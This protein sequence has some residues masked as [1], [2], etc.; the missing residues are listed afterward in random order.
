MSNALRRPAALLL[1]LSLAAVIPTVATAQDDTLDRAIEAIGG[2][3]ALSSLAG[4]VVESSGTRNALD[5]GPV[6]G[7]PAALGS[8]FESTATI[9]LAS[10]SMRIDYSIGATEFGAPREVSEIV[11][12]DVGY[13]DGQNSLVAPPGASPLLSDRVA[14]IRVQQQLLNPHLL[15]L[16][17]LADPS[18][19]SASSAGDGIEI[20]HGSTPITL[21]VDADGVLTSASTMESDPLRRDVELVVDYGDWGETTSGVSFPG[22]VSISYDGN[23]VH[24]ESRTVTTDGA[25]DQA[26][27][28]VPEGMELV[29]DAELAARG[30]VNH[31]HLQSF[32]AIGFPLDGFQPFVMAT[33]VGPGTFHLTGGSHNSM[34]VIGSDGVVV[35]EAPLNGIRMGGI[36]AWLEEQAPGLPVTHVVQSHH[37]VDHSGGLRFLAGSTGATVVAGEPAVAFYEDHVFGA[38]SEIVPDGIDGSGIAVV[39]VGAEPVVIGAGENAVTVH[40]FPNPHAEDYVLVETGGALWVVDIYNPGLGFGAPPPAVFDWVEAQ[41]LEITQVI[42]GHGGIDAWADLLAA[43]G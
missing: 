40:A 24:E 5:E 1:S 41:G 27:F 31:Q 9:D 39:G 29:F 6:P 7:G 10:D 42:G 4:F 12:G 23:V 20:T 13:V 21:T 14:S 11:T 3:D 36:L 35:I 32:E 25:I 37:H 26:A 22:S 8:P 16:D 2:T 15:L 18:M 28:A 17:V 38:T 34:A 33:E 43:R 19:A 30:D